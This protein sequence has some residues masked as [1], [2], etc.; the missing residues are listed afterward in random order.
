MAIKHGPFP[1][2]N[3]DLYLQS[4][5]IIQVFVRF[6]RVGLFSGMYRNF[7]SGIHS[8]NTAMI[9]RLNTWV[10]N[11]A[12][13]GLIF[14]STFSHAGVKVEIEGLSEALEDNAI[15]YLSLSTRAKR[16][17]EDAVR[18]SA[19][20]VRRLYGR[21][22]DEI[23]QALQPY[24]YYNP[25]I[26]SEL[27]E[28]EQSEPTAETE[29]VARFNVDTGPRV[30]IRELTVEVEGAARD[31]LQIQTLLKASPLAP[32]QALNHQQ[33]DDF[34]TSLQGA[35]YRAGFLDARFSAAEMK[36]Y[37]DQAAADIK[38]LL[39]GGQRYYF[40][41]VQIEQDILDAAFVQRFVKIEP[42][43]PFDTEKLVSLQLALADSAYFASVDIEIR[44]KDAVEFHIPVTLRADPMKPQ[45]YTTTLGYGTDTGPRA[46]LGVEF[47]RINRLGHRFSAEVEG[48]ARNA[49]LGSEYRIPVANVDQDH[50]A[51][52]FK[53]EQLEIADAQ[54]NEYSVGVRL[55]DNWWLFRR[56]LYLRYS[57]ENF[58][59]GDEPS[60]RAILLTPGISLN[61]QTADDLTYTRRGF[62]ATLDVHGGVEGP[63]TD[64]TFLQA[65]LYAHAVLPLASRARLLMRGGFGATSTK[66]FD[67]LPPSE[68]F[69]AGGDRSVRG[70]AFEALSPINENG[71]EVGGRY[72]TTG[73]I[74]VDY[75]VRGNLG[76]AAFY[77][78]GNATSDF[79]FDLKSSVGIGLRYL[80]A[81]GMIRVDIA[82][83]LDDPDTS[84][85]IHLTV[86]PDL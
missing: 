57:S 17:S 29:F 48:S 73:S 31:L 80:T 18:L 59:F 37:P 8:D 14:V 23:R 85:R 25:V 56:Q 44:R 45:K 27:E 24:G 38:L 68:R 77:D 16:A 15:A 51:F 83:P 58:R 61:Y 49:A 75:L 35:A 78:V 10:A 70:Y 50:L 13:L 7:G 41:P 74:E 32:G 12:A 52:F 42:G 5:D 6:N 82:H 2:W 69:Y 72:L 62:S 22:T 65:S 28:L 40:G 76:V 34:K 36:V 60:N 46:G 79:E 71:N 81:V 30:L 55:Q 84:F 3:E 64:T 26:S 19:D 63:L 53:T 43:D 4:S 9:M 39:K 86:G 11:L 21:A 47:R 66:H 33:Y 67:E 20:S 54:T 1:A